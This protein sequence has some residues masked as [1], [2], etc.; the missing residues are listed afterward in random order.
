MNNLRKWMTR[1]QIGKDERG[2]STVEYVIILVIVAV[3]GIGLW[4]KFGKAMTKQM[5]ANTK[6][7]NELNK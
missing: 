2:L 7:I 6:S 4:Q 3:G 1:V 5:D